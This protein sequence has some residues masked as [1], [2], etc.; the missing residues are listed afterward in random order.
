MTTRIH[1]IPKDERLRH[2]QEFWIDKTILGMNEFSMVFK[3]FAALFSRNLALARGF[4][5]KNWEKAND[6]FGPLDIIFVGDL[7]QI[8]PV[9]RGHIECLFTLEDIQERSVLQIT[10]RRIYQSFQTT[11]VLK[12]LVIVNRL[13]SIGIFIDNSLG[14]STRPVVAIHIRSHSTVLCGT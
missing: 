3:T 1:D 14:T 4:D 12:K 9:A 5:I 7:H 10:R 6:M 11:V 13:E 8:L 2:L